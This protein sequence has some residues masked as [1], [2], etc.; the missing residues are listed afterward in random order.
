MRVG[1]ILEWL[2][3]AALVAAAYLA[4]GLAWPPLVAA[5]IVLAYEAQCHAHLE[6]RALRRGQ[7]PEAPE[8][9]CPECHAPVGSHFP[10]CP[11]RG[12]Q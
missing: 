11:I 2:A 9:P 7:R 8:V 12:S 4:T 3:G 1:D 5:G 6:L 10:T